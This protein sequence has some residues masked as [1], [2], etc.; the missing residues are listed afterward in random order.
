MLLPCS[1]HVQTRYKR[2]SKPTASLRIRGWKRRNT[3]SVP[4][5]LRYVLLASSCGLLPSQLAKAG[6]AAKSCE[7]DAEQSDGP[8][9]RLRLRGT[10][11]G[12]G[13]QQSRG[14]VSQQRI[15]RPRID[16]E[17]SAATVRFFLGN[18]G[19]TLG[20]DNFNLRQIIF[21]G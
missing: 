1:D 4:L 7:P 20:H 18:K 14:A 5:D 6:E 8:F 17:Q 15:S 10:R 11:G 16:G 2:W 9:A 13:S 21:Y 3:A 19:L 12:G